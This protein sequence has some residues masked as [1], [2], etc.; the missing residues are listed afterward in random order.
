MTPPAPAAKAPAPAKPDKAE[1]T[2]KGS[3][4]AKAEKADKVPKSA[5]E[6]KPAPAAT[7]GRLVPGKF[8]LN[9]GVYAQAANVDKAVQQLQGA[10]LNALRQTVSSSKGD[11]T[12][13]RI[14]PFD[15]RQ[16]AEQAA[17]KAK[18]LR[19][20]ASVFQHPRG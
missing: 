13:L 5:P 2:D 12:R 9:A 18:Q 20:D 14:G 11:L 10:K 19:I 6:P 4:T 8:Y 3:K 17:A 7:N 15:T 16:Q 1:K